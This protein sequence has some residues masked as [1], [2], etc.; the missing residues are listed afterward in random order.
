MTPAI[1]PTSARTSAK[2][3]AQKRAPKAAGMGAS[4]ADPLHADLG[5]SL[6]NTA[7]NCAT[8]I[9]AGFVD[10][11]KPVYWSE[12]DE[13]T[14]EVLPFTVEV[15]R[16]REAIAKVLRTPQKIR[17]ERYMLK[18]AAAEIL[19]NERVA[20]CLRWR[21][22]DSAIQ[23]LKG[24]EH[25]K[26]FYSGLQVCASPWHCPVC[27]AK[28]SERRREELRRAL[29]QAKKLGL[30]VMLLTLT[31]RHGIGDD[32]N[33]ITDKM[34]KAWRN[35]NS[36]TRAGKELHKQIGFKGSIRAIEVTHGGDNGF[37]PHIHAL[38]FLDSDVSTT[39]VQA[40]YSALW[41]VACPRVGLPA[42][43]DA[44]GCRV[45]DNR[46]AG[47][48]VSKWG[49][50]SEMVKGHTKIAA[51]GK[52]KTPWDLLRA[53]IEDNDEKSRDLFKVY[54]DAFKGRR[55]LH[56]SIGLKALLSIADMTDEE[57]VNQQDEPAYVLAELTV[58]EWRAIYKNKK[59]SA[60]LDIAENDP[61]GLMDFI[62]SF[63]F[64]VSV[65]QQKRKICDDV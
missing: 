32:V 34:L 49:L 45:D 36:G 48:Y 55:Q 27:S 58:E 5:V 29:V 28:I 37:H 6:G 43:S 47:L 51:D 12:A 50:E 20:K 33:A 24:K 40:G 22:K 15:T 39:T 52:G 9:P 10:Q 56:W 17:A 25:K 7:F 23:I 44:R 18:A 64:L 42:P 38:L 53:W 54:A 61:A 62:K 11:K 1:R 13:E 59:E 30:K 14:G 16:S 46:G 41:Q 2:E 60:V 31:I 26:A 19:P 57:L 4:E 8:R 65:T 3:Q 21:K 63:V 35:V